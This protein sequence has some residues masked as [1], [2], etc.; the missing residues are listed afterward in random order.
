MVH[1][2]REKEIRVPAPTI[3]SYVLGTFCAIKSLFCLYLPCQII[4]GINCY[5]KDWDEDPSLP[6]VFW[7]PTLAAG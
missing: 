2:E 5:P 4:L 3:D 6:L 1:V 7:C